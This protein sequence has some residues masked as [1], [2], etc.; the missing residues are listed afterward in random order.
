[1]SPDEEGSMNI[2][3]EILDEFK[4]LC[5]IPHGSGFEFNIGEHIKKRLKEIGAEVQQDE[6][7]NILGYIPAFNGKE[8]SP[9]TI[10]QAHMDMVIAGDLPQEEAIVNTVEENG[11]LRTDGHTTLGADNGIGVAVILTILKHPPVNHGPIRGIFTVSE[12]IGLKGAKEVDKSWLNG[13]S[14]MINTDGF[15]SDI[16]V[17]GCK[18]GLRET[19]SRPVDIE[20]LNHEVIFHTRKENQLDDTELYEVKL[21]G[22]LGGHSG[23]DIDKG[24]C[25]TIFQLAEILEDVQDRYDMRI[26]SMEGGAGY[27]VI[28][29]ECTAVVAVPKACIMSVGR[30]LRKEDKDIHAEFE[31]SDPTGTLT[32]KLLGETEPGNTLWSYDFQRDVLRLLRYM[33]EGISTRDVDG[34]VTSSCNL[35]R[36]TTEEGILKVGNMLR[37]DT[38]DQEDEILKQHEQVALILDFKREVV[39]YHSW[40]SEKDGRLVNTITEIYEKNNGIPMRVKV[41]QVGLEP[42]YFSQMAPELE[43]V[44]LGADIENAHSVKENVNIES[45]VSLYNIIFESLQK[46]AEA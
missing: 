34:E 32:V 41:A 13:A 36:L 16:V 28:P 19:L 7:G 8:D 23:D 44:C 15:H 1:M 46:L 3:K 18:G 43:I 40:H 22:Y 26:A 21:Q 33:K 14:Y 10:L 11:F 12:E 31:H 39:G 45:V 38:R 42:A 20:K 35:G 27:N 4:L 9:I 2:S 5:G 25:N 29:A 30:L 6:T 24:R 17:V 37:C